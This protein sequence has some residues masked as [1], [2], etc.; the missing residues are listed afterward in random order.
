MS[1]DITRPTLS[2]RFWARVDR[3]DGCWEWRGARAHLGHGL[4]FWNGRSRPAT[5]LALHLAGKPRPEGHEACHRC[6]NPPCVNPAHLYWGTRQDNVDDA[7]ARGRRSGGERH[8]SAR[9]T[10]RQVVELRH[11]FATGVSRDELAKRYGIQKKTVND[12][13]SG[14]KWPNAA[15]PRTH[16]KAA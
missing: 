9:L 16:R 15:G 4:V 11:D 10:E 7:Y 5:H 3:S 8:A 2:E 12:I 1:N 6:D 14:R 13:A